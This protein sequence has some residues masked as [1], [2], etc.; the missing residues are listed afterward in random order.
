MSMVKIINVPQSEGVYDTFQI[1]VNGEAVQACLC[2]VSAMPF[3]IWWPGRQRSIEQ[4]ELAGVLSVVADEP[5]TVTVSYDGAQ[6]KPIVRPL[7]KNITA[8]CENGVTA[9]TIERAGDYV[10]EMPSEHECIHIFVDAPKDFSVYGTPTHYFGAGVHEVG[11]ITL[12]SGD[13]VFIDENAYVKGVLYGKDVKDV[14][15]Y[16]YGRLDGG[17]EERKNSRC[18]E[19]DTN[20]CVKLYDCEDVLLEGITLSDSAVWV[21][22]VFHS[23]N[24]VVEN[25][26]IVGH[27]RYNTDGID[28]VNSS[29]VFIRN[30]FIRAFDDAIT[31]KGIAYYAQSPI[32]NIFV[33]NCI[34]WCGWGRT[35]EI[36]LET[37]AEKYE[38][39][40]FSN[41]DLIHNSAVA[42]DIQSG[43][44]AEISNVSYR[45][46][47][48]EYSKYTTPE[49]MENPLGVAYTGAG[50]LH[51]PT[52]IK[53]CTQPYALDGEEYSA[54]AALHEQLRQGRYAFM[55][56][57]AFEN[58]TVYLED[59]LAFPEIVI[60]VCPPAKLGKVRIKNIQTKQY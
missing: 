31:L 41:C 50:K 26:K 1:N 47:R 16:G 12:K 38:N 6:G 44:Y 33:E 2:R 39:I 43:D 7:H 51:L 49:V 40:H 19:E 52:L 58:I 13:R 36:G 32:E 8:V 14:K 29:N 23:Q 4:T 9:F 11:K 17:M 15:I 37:V 18:Y 46:I 60:D 48:V 3:N 21:L 59:E 56:D 57:I 20:G 27:W 55:H 25:I 42:L 22:N 24:V 5:I 53:V 34:L 30:S 10:L 54:Y 28:V 45:D 35:L